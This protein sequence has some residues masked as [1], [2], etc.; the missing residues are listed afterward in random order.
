MWLR[1]PV[2]GARQSDGCAAP[3]GGLL[4][5]WTAGIVE[6]EQ[7]CRLVEGLAKRIVQGGAEARVLADLLDDEK[8]RVTARDEQQEIG[9]SQAMG[10]AR[11]ERV[12]FEMVHG[13]EGQP[14]R[15]RDRLARGNADDQP[16]DQPRPSGC[17]DAVD[18][19]EAETGFGQR[20][21]DQDIEQ[22][23]MGARRDLRHDAAERGVQRKLRA[24]HIGEDDALAACLTP[25]QGGGGLVAARLDAEHDEVA[26]VWSSS[27]D[28][29]LQAK[30]GAIEEYD[31][32]LSI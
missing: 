18:A 2:H 9:K 3:L 19:V 5:G 31:A 26:R 12:R 15:K 13:D 8:L 20:L 4:D 21:G 6:A 23:D 17:G 24:H 7:L 11:C 28:A 29:S 10:E 16:A 30:T 1:P 32:F 27:H 22:L 25:H 14:A